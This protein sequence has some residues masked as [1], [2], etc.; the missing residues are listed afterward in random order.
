MT[1]KRYDIYGPI[2]K[3]LRL[4][5]A[6]M[7]KALGRADFTAPD[8]ILAALRDHLALCAKHLTHEDEHIHPALEART[9]GAAAEAERQHEE[10]RED[11]ERMERAMAAV[12]RAAPADR[13]AAGRQLYLTYTTFVAADLAHMHA[14][15]TVLFPQLCAVFTDEEL[16]AIEMGIIA[17]LPPEENIA[18]MRLMIPAINQAERAEL[19][20]GV[21]AGAPPEAFDAILRHAVR[22][23][24]GEAD[25]AALDRLGLAA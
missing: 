4:A 25:L 11:F 6:D 5:H 18:F 16:A 8:D 9:H 13:P 24:L 19:L 20:G 21:K 15:E 12:E 3:G 17:S 1:T 14:E 7:L 22:P 10:H 2:H 23:T